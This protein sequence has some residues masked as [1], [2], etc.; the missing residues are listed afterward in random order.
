MKII[1]HGDLHQA[2]KKLNPYTRFECL[3]C[4]AIFECVGDEWHYEEGQYYSH[5]TANCPTCG[6]KCQRVVTTR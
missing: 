6:Q 2:A 1:K 5:P 4:G 3:I